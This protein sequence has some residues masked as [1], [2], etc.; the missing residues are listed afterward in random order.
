MSMISQSIY[1]NPELLRQKFMCAIFPA[2]NNCRFPIKPSSSGAKY[3]PQD[4]NQFPSMSRCYSPKCGVVCPGS[5]WL[6]RILAVYSQDQVMPCSGEIHIFWL[7][8][9]FS[10][11]LSPVSPYRVSLHF[12]CSTQRPIIWGR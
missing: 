1:R 9:C 11:V 8:D 10:V 12:T 3:V 6:Q 4:S 7:D 2:E 5:Q